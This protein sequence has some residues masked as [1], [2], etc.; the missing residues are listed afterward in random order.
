MLERELE[1]LTDTVRAKG[2]VRL[3]VVLA[4]EEVTAVLRHMLGEFWLASSL[5][6]GAGLRL[7]E[8]LS[9]RIKDDVE[10]ARRTIVVRDGKGR[11]DRE[12]VFPRKL[13]APLQKHLEQVRRQHEADLAAGAGSVALPDALATKYPRTPWE[14][15]WQWMFPARR[16]YVDPDT[17]Q[18]R[19]HHLH[20]CCQ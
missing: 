11:K 10:F 8:C 9:T 12:T 18:I 2:P 15:A 13:V 1:G 16:A 7:L 17:G 14:W 20:G 3:P 5:M 19:R 4:R 6:Y